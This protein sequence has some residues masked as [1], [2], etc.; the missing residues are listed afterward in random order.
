MSYASF[1]L[2]HMKP[3]V[4]AIPC[5]VETFSS[6]QMAVFKPSVIFEG[7]ARFQSYEFL[8]AAEGIPNLRIENKQISV[9]K[10]GFVS[11]NPMQSHG[12]LR[13]QSVDKYMSIFIDRCM[14]NENAYSIAGSVDIEFCSTPCTYHPEVLSI[15]QSFIREC[16]AKQ[17]GHDFVVQS[18]T[19]Q[20]I[21]ALI[22]NSKNSVSSRVCSQSY[23]EDRNMNLAIDYL[24]ENFDKEFSF[25]D[26]AKTIN[27]S[28]YHFIR[29]FKDVTGKTPH[30]YLLDI[31]IQKALD[32]LRYSNNTVTEICYSSGFNNLNHFSSLFKKKI[33]VSPTEY[34][35]NVRF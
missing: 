35:K 20:F 1:V 34:R 14:F 13:Q 32:L 7:P 8:L 22:R 10:Q 24:W 23:K 17:L 9:G 33:G 16:S 11:I 3:I 31:K 19:I 5:N 18:I 25:E 30:E 27:Y 12:A 28:P 21:A 2:E 15:L 29:I 6:P 4:P 26:I